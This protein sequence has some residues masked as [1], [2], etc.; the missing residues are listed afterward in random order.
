MPFNTVVQAALAAGAKG[1][2]AVKG[3]QT[4]GL[5]ADEVASAL[6]AQVFGF[7]DAPA[8]GLLSVRRLHTAP[9]AAPQST[10]ASPVI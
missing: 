3:A 8:A 10:V 7:S 5:T 4:S 9:R 1:S 6:S 2:D